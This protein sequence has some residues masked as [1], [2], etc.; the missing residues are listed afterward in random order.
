MP[1]RVLGAGSDATPHCTKRRRCTRSALRIPAFLHSLLT[2][3]RF[4]YLGLTGTGWQGRQPKSSYRSDRMNPLPL[5][6]RILCE[7]QSSLLLVAQ[8]WLKRSIQMRR[9]AHFQE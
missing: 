2:T 9:G 1:G 6:V 4:C 3:H 5:G 8:R 7:K